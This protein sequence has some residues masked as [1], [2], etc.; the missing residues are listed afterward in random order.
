MVGGGVHEDGARFGRLAAK[1]PA[2]RMTE[3]VE[4]LL[5]LF[6]AERAPG[7]IGPRR[8]SGA[9]TSPG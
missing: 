7:E 3:A 1:V 8:S 4:R 2:R 9:W 6:G 5:D